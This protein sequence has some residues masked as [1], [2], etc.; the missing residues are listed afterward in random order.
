MIETRPAW[1]GKPLA[2]GSPTH[3]S[4]ARHGQ[5]PDPQAQAL[6]GVQRFRGG[7]RTGESLHAGAHVRDALQPAGEVEVLAA[8]EAVVVAPAEQLPEP[9]CREA[10]EHT[11]VLPEQCGETVQGIRGD[12]SRVRREPS[13]PP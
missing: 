11:K 5:L 2:G 12:A 7:Q 10:R 1:S 8:R 4:R 6:A 3:R 9:G 13:A